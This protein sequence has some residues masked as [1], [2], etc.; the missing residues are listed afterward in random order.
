MWSTDCCQFSSAASAA[1]GVERSPKALHE[2]ES[3]LAREQRRRAR[4]G[5]EAA[6][7][8]GSVESLT[9]VRFSAMGLA[10]NRKRLGLS[11]EAFGRLVGATGQGVYAWVGAR[12]QQAA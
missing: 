2:I 11:T 12:H 9:R 8:D 4:P 10:S 7:A 5:R 6:E 1:Q 3:R